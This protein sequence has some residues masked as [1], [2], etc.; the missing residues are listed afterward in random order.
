MLDTA[1]IYFYAVIADTQKPNQHNINN[2]RLVSF[3]FS[4]TNVRYRVL[5]YYPYVHTIITVFVTMGS[6]AARKLKRKYV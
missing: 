2:G 1:V 5:N 4:D 6:N 3:H